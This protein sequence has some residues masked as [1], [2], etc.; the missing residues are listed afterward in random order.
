MKPANTQLADINH[1]IVELQ[2]KNIIIKTSVFNQKLKHLKKTSKYYQNDNGNII[3][4]L[5]QIF[6]DSYTLI[7]K[8]YI[9]KIQ[10]SIKEK[11]LNEHDILNILIIGIINNINKLNKL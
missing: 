3:I 10:E 2:E 4:D 7:E 5:E 11:K 6:E 8:K 9:G 1:L